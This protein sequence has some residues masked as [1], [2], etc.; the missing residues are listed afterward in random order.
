MDSQ[1]TARKRKGQVI[2]LAPVIV[3]VLGGIASLATDIG[4][5][6]VMEAQLQNAADASALAATQVLVAQ[7]SGGTA[8]SQARATAL[9]EAET[10]LT[11]NSSTAGMALEFGTWDGSVFTALPSSTAATAIRVVT[12]RSEDAPGG[13]LDLFFASLIGISS[14]DMEAS[15]ICETNSFIQS[16]VANL[17]PFAVPEAGIPGIGETM[18][19]YPAGEGNGNNGNNG[20]SGGQTS[21]GNWGLLDLNGGSN[22]T[23]ELRG[24]I[25]NGYDGEFS[26]GPDGY[27]WLEGDTGFRATLE[28]EIRSRIGDQLIMLIYDQVTGQG[29]N[30]QY[31]CIGFLLATILDCELNGNN[32]FATCRVDAVASWHWLVTGGNTESANLRK[33]QL[34]K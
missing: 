27:V 19:F 11:E 15:A 30:T 3:L 2:I 4:M 17:S 33:V 24:W 8:E 5:M 13:P 31:R 12:D 14:C 25:L 29:S 22:S 16:I 1:Q 7:R 20:N 23:T 34:V 6:F 26:I 9:A 18:T 32:K 28:T 21:S 10:F